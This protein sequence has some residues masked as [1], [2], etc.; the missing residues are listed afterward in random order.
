MKVTNFLHKSSLRCEDR[1]GYN[2]HFFI[3]FML[4]INILFID[5]HA[6]IIISYFLSFCTWLFE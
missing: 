2:V 6:F 1:I 4:A 5:L 3:Y